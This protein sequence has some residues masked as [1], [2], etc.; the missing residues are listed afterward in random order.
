LLFYKKIARFAKSH[1][2]ASGSIFLEI[3]ETLGEEVV[4]LYEQAGYKVEIRKDL[5]GKDRM[6]KINY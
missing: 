2:A 4:A 5:Q 3:N 1:L 6:G